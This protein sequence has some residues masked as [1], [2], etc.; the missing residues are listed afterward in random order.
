M[1]DLLSAAWF[2]E[3]RDKLAAIEPLGD[4]SHELALGQIVEDSPSGEVAWTIHI[5][6]GQPARFEAGVEH[7]AVTIIENFETMNAL[8]GGAT[9]TELLYEGRLKISGDVSALLSCA[10]LLAQLNAAI[11]S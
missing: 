9:T 4:A 7:A 8:I 1:A 11:A 10:D 3:L 5:G 6:G 2:K